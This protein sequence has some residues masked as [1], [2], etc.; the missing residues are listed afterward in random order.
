MSAHVHLH[1]SFLHSLRDIPFLTRKQSFC[2]HESACTSNAF[3]GVIR[4]SAIGY[5]VKASISIA[6]G[7]LFKKMYKEPK[8]ILDIIFGKDA[9]NFSVFLG[10][11]SGTYKIVQCLMRLLRQKEDGLNAFIAGGCAGLT[12]YF[13]SKSRWLDIS[14][15]VAARAIASVLT[16]YFGTSNKTSANVPLPPPRNLFEK[17]YRIMKSVSTSF[18]SLFLNNFDVLVFSGLVGALIVGFIYEPWNLS[19]SYYK[20][21]TKM[22]KSSGDEHVAHNYRMAYRKCQGLHVDPETL[23]DGPRRV[24]DQDSDEEQTQNI[25]PTSD[26]DVN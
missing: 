8:K 18:I 6:L 7:V 25:N 13:D 16:M 19:P 2:R 20:I 4:G 23:E 1:E 15:Y 24:E 12:L 3:R 21:F 17:V 10:A 26:T 14:T 11:F 5:C 22:E 9:Y